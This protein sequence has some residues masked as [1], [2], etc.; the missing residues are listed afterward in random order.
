MYTRADQ[1]T[2]PPLAITEIVHS[3]WAFKTLHA[4]VELEIF[5]PL[6]SED[7]TAQ[8]VA[9]ELKL[10]L[11]GT[12]VILDAL[13][14]MGLLEKADQRYRLGDSARTYLLKQSQLYL[15]DFVRFAQR[16]VNESWGTLA[17][18]VRVGKP[19]REVNK[20][21][22]A[23]QFFP[24]L[25]A[26]I[27]PLNYSTAHLVV[28]ALKLEALPKGA[29][30][31]DVATG[32]GVWSIP[33]A[34]RNRAVHIDA[35]DF[36]AVLEVVREF[37][38]KSSVDQQYSYL[39][40]D[41]RALTLDANAYDLIIIG[42]LL[43]SEGRQASRELLKKLKSAIKDGG[44][45]VVAEFMPNEGRTAPLGPLLF[46]VNMFLQTSDGCVFNISEL[47]DL[48]EG[49]GFNDAC[50]LELPFYGHESPVVV[51]KG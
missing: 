14:A 35:L 1:R 6:K 25:A 21:E 19:A 30:I 9:S 46:A 20:Q 49:A 47:C 7:K 33:I 43:H 24:K 31:L 44:K 27:F 15:G 10:N 41:W 8:V 37:A 36:P 39:S 40:G 42:H 51:A 32:S 26:A 12:T 11:Q 45:L 38:K 22:T 17:E 16:A 4:A 3:D 13:V 48:I 5:E 50:R 23:E 28:D 2:V 29:R 34:E 18:C